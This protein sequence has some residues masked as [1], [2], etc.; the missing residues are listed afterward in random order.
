MRGTAALRLETCLR[1]SHQEAHFGRAHG[2]EGDSGSG[3]RGCC[4]SP[5]GSKEASA[6]GAQG[7]MAAA[8]VRKPNT[9]APRVAVGAMALPRGLSAE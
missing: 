8:V 1:S 2:R 3:E 9:G 7:E 4:E 5:C 6:I